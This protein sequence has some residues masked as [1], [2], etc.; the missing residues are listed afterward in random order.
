M[1]VIGCMI[2]NGRFA[3][4]YGSDVE[5]FLVIRS[6]SHSQ[7]ALGHDQFHLE[8]TTRF[9]TEADAQNWIDKQ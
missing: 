2:Y 6:G 5:F 4:V 3:V 1:E 8:T 9:D 7:T